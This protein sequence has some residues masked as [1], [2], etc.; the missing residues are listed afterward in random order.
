[1]I[2][3]S[4]TIPLRG[5]YVKISY[6]NRSN[7]LCWRRG[8]LRYINYKNLAI[9]NPLTGYLY[10]IPYSAVQEVKEVPYEES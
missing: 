2:T 3:R 10:R 9:E 1:M 6:L 5:C 8:E 4:Q 7:V